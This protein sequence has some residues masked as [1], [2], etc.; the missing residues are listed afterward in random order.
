MSLNLDAVGQE[1][2]SQELAVHIWDDGAT[3]RF[4]TKAGDTVVL[5]NGM[6]TKEP[7]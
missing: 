7:A 3:A 1:W 2:E 5:D 4:L 6:F